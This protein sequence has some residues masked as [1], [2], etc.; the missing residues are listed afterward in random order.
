[1]TDRT[2]HLTLSV[3]VRELNKE[4]LKDAGFDFEE[5]RRFME[6]MGDDPDGDL[7]LIDEACPGELSD[8]IAT[9]LASEDTVTEMFAG[10]NM[11]LTFGEVYVVTSDWVD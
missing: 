11:F 9:A 4:E 8:M 5:H 6:E 1:M 2:L 10:S 3:K 7:K